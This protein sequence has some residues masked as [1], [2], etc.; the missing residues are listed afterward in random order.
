MGCERAGVWVVVGWSW[1]ATLAACGASRE[2]GRAIKTGDF[3]EAFG[4]SV[5]FTTNQHGGPEPTC[6][7]PVCQELLSVIRG[8]HISI[9]F[10]VYGMRAQPHVI[11][12]LVAA[13]QRGVVVRGVVDSENADCTAFGY[14]DTPNLI[15]ALAPGS[16]HC[17]LGGGYSYI[18]HNKFF[19]IDG[20]KVWTGST[21]VSD[22]ELGGEYNSDVAALITSY[23]IAQIYGGEFA[24][25]FEAGLF[26]KRKSD[27]TLHV[28]DG[29]HFTDGTLVKSYFSPTDHALDNAVLPLIDAA[30]ATL[31]IAMFYFTTQEIADAI[32]SAR[33]R[34]VAVRMILDAG[35]AG[36]AYSKHSQ[37]CSAGIP[38]KTENW[39]GKSH[40]KWAVADAR[41]GGAAAVVF[42]SM[43][44]TRA[45]DTD[46]DENT[47]YVKN[48]GFAAPFRA[49]FERQWAE[50]AGVPA[51]TAVSIE[52]ADS[53]VCSPANNCAASCAGGSCCDGIDNDYDGK[54]D[55]AEEA[56]ACADGIDND[57]DGYIDLDDW[58]CRSIDDPE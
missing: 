53:S 39:G 18:M 48:D 58:D 54:I 29:A 22:T 36:N 44:W 1:L 16:V 8:A 3:P 23:K 4:Y 17:D 38:V 45:G 35:G 51:C 19:V 34:G 6:N 30:A 42:G 55:L 20:Q 43:N 52:G 32:V 2:P 15:G 7:R 47:L 46:N 37:L 10:A 21:N 25:M 33:S 40:S 12:A 56:C 26:H 24:E 9:D 5:K 14:P 13:Q 27:N 50:L 31:D 41:I 28:V 57:G 11:D 49:E